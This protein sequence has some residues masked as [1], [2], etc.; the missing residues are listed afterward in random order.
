MEGVVS[1]VVGVVVVGVQGERE[2]KG[3]S[4]RKRELGFEDQLTTEKSKSFRRD[5]N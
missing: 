3:R 4:H 1:F 2:G 5:D